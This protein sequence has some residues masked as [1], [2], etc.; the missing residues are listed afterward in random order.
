M[1]M[2]KLE[3]LDWENTGYFCYRKWVFTGAPVAMDSKP[4]AQPGSN[5]NREI[6]SSSPFY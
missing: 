4:D 6:D 5:E 3:V 1:G 2:R